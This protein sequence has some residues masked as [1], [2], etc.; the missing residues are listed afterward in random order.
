MGELY[1][2]LSQFHFA[3]D[4]DTC[5]YFV[6]GRRLVGVVITSDVY[7]VGGLVELAAPVVD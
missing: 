2:I 6:D 3:R 5:Q 4:V 7:E 1:E